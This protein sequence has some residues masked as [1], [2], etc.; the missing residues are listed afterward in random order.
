MDV[1]ENQIERL[2]RR[3]S[4]QKLEIRV[5]ELRSRQAAAQ[6]EA[7]RFDAALAQVRA[8]SAPGPQDELPFDRQYR[9]SS[10]RLRARLRAELITP[11]QYETR[12]AAVAATRAERAIRWAK[13]EDRALNPHNPRAKVAAQLTGRALRAR[14]RRG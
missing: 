11:A 13:Y 12:L 1:Y 5:Q 6:E 3:L 10:E 4:G 8:A 14:A 7:T 2:R 9:E